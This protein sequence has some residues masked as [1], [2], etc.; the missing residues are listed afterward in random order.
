MSRVFG[1]D[2]Y[3]CWIGTDKGAIW[4]FVAP[5]LVIISVRTLSLFIKWNIF[6]YVGESYYLN[7]GTSIHL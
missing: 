1:F 2:K 6:I 7:F 5:M 4:G 3:S